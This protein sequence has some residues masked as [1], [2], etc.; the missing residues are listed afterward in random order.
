MPI[1]VYQCRDCGENLEK[2]QK[3]SD[4]VLVDCPA[5]GKPALQKMVTAAGFRLKGSGWYETDFKTEGKR[6]L[7][8]DQDAGD[9]ASATDKATA[10]KDSGDSKTGGKSDADSG[11]KKSKSGDESKSKPKADAKTDAK[12]DA[13]PKTKTKD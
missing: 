8:G 13:K 10:D 2:L 11:S 1:Y 7:A 5:C 4:P 3:I 6:N 9:K 12:S